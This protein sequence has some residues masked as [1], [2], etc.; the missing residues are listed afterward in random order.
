MNFK[1]CLFALVLIVSSAAVASDERL[2]EVK[3]ISEMVVKAAEQHVLEVIVE[4]SSKEEL[5]EVIYD[6]LQQNKLLLAALAKLKNNS[7]IV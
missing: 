3:R 1:N 2:V 6:L 7:I 5:A 4:D